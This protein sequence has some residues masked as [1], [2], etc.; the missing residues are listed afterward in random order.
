[1]ICSFCSAEQN[2]YYSKEK[3]LQIVDV[4]GKKTLEQIQK[5]F[6]TTDLS[7]ITIDETKEAAKI[8]NGN[9][10]K[11]D[12]IKEAKDSKK[13]KD[14][15]KKMKEQDLMNKLNLTQSDIENLKLITR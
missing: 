12:F 10:V 15:E 1:M 8:A 7:V 6:N 3:N 2:I 11:Y 13:Q 9:L 14:D 4:S 5:E